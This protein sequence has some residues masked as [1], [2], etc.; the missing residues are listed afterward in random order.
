MAYVSLVHITDI[1]YLY[2][3]GKPRSAATTPPLPSFQPLHT[4]PSGADVFSPSTEDTV[5]TIFP[6]IEE[7]TRRLEEDRPGA[8]FEN[9]EEVL[10]DA[11]VTRSPQILL[12][13]E[14]VLCTAINI[15]LPRARILR[16]HTRRLIM[17]VLGFHRIYDEPEFELKMEINTTNHIVSSTKTKTVKFLEDSGDSKCDD[18]EDKDDD[19][20]E[21]KGDKIPI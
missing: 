13:P 19:D 8:G 14:D 6:S 21:G 2:E 10:L 12:I 3:Q 5:D 4:W 18:A 20:A 16:N 15:S 7:V 17:P 11:G 9:L 1:Y